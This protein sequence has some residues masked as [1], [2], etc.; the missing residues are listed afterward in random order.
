LQRNLAYCPCNHAPAIM[1]SHCNHTITFTPL[2]SCVH[3][4]LSI[5]IECN[6]NDNQEI[7]LQNSLSFQSLS[8]YQSLSR[9]TPFLCFP[10]LFYSK[11]LM[12]SSSAFATTTSST[13]AFT[14]P[15]LTH[16]SSL[17]DYSTCSHFEDS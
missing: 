9:P 15:N 11:P 1:Q 7:K 16:C 8:W 2:I 17:L 3:R 6:T 4:K 12:A 5:Y 13:P 10:T 14:L